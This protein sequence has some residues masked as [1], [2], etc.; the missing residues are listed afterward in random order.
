MSGPSFLACV[1]ST[2]TLASQVSER[3]ICSKCISMPN[4]WFWHDVREHNAS[5]VASDRASIV[6][7][8]C[9]VILCLGKRFLFSHPFKPGRAEPAPFTQNAAAAGAQI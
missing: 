7:A 2:D 1:F 3:S 5:I 4:L 6:A 9:V 8:S